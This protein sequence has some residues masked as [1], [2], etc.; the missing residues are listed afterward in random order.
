MTTG[1]RDEFSQGV[2]RALAHGVR[3]LCSNPSC[4]AP[5]AGP[6]KDPSK[7][8]SVGVAAHITGASPGGP[9]FD[10]KMTERERRGASNGIWLCQDWAK[11][12][13][14]DPQTFTGRLLAGW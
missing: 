4:R 8:V 5:T 6:Q 13:D 14:R 2:K 11:L 9:R 3:L 10:S 7:A 1:W 12:I